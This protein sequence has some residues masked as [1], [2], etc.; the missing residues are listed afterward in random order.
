MWKKLR[1]LILLFIL[2]TVALS[3]WRGQARA[4]DWH[5]TVQV[6][7]FPINGDGSTAAAKRIAGLSD[8]SFRDIEEFFVEQAHA[9]G[10]RETHPLRVSLQPA[11]NSLPPRPP[12]TGSAFDILVWSLQLRWWAWKQPEGSPRAGVRAFVIYWDSTQTEGRIPDSHGL[13]KGQIAI[14]NVHVQQDM[15]RT[16]NVVIAHEILHTMAATDKYGP[17]LMPVFPDGFAEPGAS[18][19]YPQRLCE[20]MAGRIPLSASQ[21]EMPHSLKDCVIGPATAR[22]IGIT[23]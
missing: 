16:N 14:S 21:L 4:R 15:Q 11:L 22:E 6:A 17:D 23:H 2:A 7:I 18:P 10:V 8:D 19:R 9:H 3:A 13:A 1:I 12:S 5:N 20:I